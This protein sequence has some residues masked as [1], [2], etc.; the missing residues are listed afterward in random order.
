[1]LNSR[2]MNRLLMF[3]VLTCCYSAAVAA[4][5]AFARLDLGKF[6]YQFTGSTPVFADYTDLGFLSEDLLLISINQRGFGPVEPLF[7]DSPE[8]TIVVFDVKRA[9]VAATAKMSVEKM[10]GSVQAIS[11]ERFAVLNEKGLQFCN[12]NLRCVSPME[13]A[14]GP[15]FVSPQGKRMAV[16]GSGRTE[17]LIDTE[18]SKQ[19][20]GF[21]PY[22]AIFPP[23]IP[24]DEVS[25]VRRD[26]AII[27][28]RPGR[29]EIS[30]D[31]EAKEVFPEFRF[32]NLGLVACLD[33][34]ASDVVVSGLDG[35]EFHRYKVK[36]AWRTGILPAASGTRFG[37]Y[38]HGYTALNSLLNL[39]DIDE[40]RPQDFQR[41]RVIDI[42]SGKEVYQLEWDPRPY[43]TKPA[44]SPSG[45]RLAR[46]KAGILEV[47]QVN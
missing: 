46:V 39:L 43:L 38:E 18:S 2:Q 13:A 37:I 14:T 17:S 12:Q 45:H 29:E 30:I 6:G 24:G 27:L 33:H 7:A 42:S 28:Q 1:M 15:M 36:D 23:V 35:K 19:I 31:I 26:N 8:S 34:D 9:S 11:R 4:D 41:V 40:G 25:I 3:L 22:R 44:L 10:S 16:R 20:A 47:F 5:V 32:L 21:E